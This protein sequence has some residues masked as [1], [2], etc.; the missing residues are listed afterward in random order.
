MGFFGGGSLTG[1]GQHVEVG[2]EAVHVQTDAVTAVR[3]PKDA[4][5]GDGTLRAARHPGKGGAWG[6]G[7]AMTPPYGAETPPIGRRPPP[8][9][10]I[11][12]R[13]A[14]TPPIGLRPPPWG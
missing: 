9:A 1:G 7:T 5:N 2:G 4:Q 14:E 10:E 3:H 12:P 6:G 13:R 11:P 8:I